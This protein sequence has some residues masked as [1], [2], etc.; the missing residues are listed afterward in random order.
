M[1]ETVLRSSESSLP[2]ASA[3]VHPYNASAPLLALGDVRHR[4]DEEHAL[5]I[6]TYGTARDDANVLD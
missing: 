4:P 6:F 3:A 2:S 5:R 1:G